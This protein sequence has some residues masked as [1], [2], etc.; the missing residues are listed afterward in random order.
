MYL[1]NNYCLLLLV[2]LLWFC[3]G[4]GRS[5]RSRVRYNAA[6]ARSSRF[7]FEFFVLWVFWSELR[8]LS[9]RCCV[10]RRIKL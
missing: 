10:C 3:D 4:R 7:F 6:R 9:L 1:Y 5:F 8:I 2:C